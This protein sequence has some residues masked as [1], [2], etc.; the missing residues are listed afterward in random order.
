MIIKYNNSLLFLFSNKFSNQ[1]Y[2]CFTNINFANNI[3]KSILWFNL[4]LPR[5]YYFLRFNWNKNYLSIK[6]PN[7]N[8]IYIIKNT[9][10]E[11]ELHK[12]KNQIN[13]IINHYYNILIYLKT[14]HKK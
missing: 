2:I 5:D 12:N 3:I 6:P 11:I 9:G 7:S 1:Y 4:N 14:Y 8:N 10:N 13:N